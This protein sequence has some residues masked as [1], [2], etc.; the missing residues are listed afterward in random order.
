M[1]YLL[2]KVEDS[3]LGWQ[4]KVVGSLPFSVLQKFTYLSVFTFFFFWAKQ[5][6]IYVSDIFRGIL[7]IIIFVWVYWNI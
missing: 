2:E 7:K 5:S 1:Y 3:K 6:Y 4:I